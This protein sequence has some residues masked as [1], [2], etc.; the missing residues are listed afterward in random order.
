[1]IDCDD[2]FFVL[3]IRPIVRIV[4]SLYLSNCPV[5]IT[6]CHIT[7]GLCPNEQT[8]GGKKKKRRNNVRFCHKFLKDS[9][10]FL[11]VLLT[12]P[13]A[14]SLARIYILICPINVLIYVFLPG[15]TLRENLAFWDEVYWIQ[16]AQ[17]VQYIDILHHILYTYIYTRKLRHRQLFSDLW[18][19]ETHLYPW[20]LVSLKQQKN[21]RKIRLLDL[22]TTWSFKIHYINNRKRSHL[23]S[24]DAWQ[25]FSYYIN[26]Y[27]K[28][29]S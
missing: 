8:S 14:K 17:I 18:P 5:N 24:D 27:D 15:V 13:I 4:A 2:I 23:Q 11:C 21:W 1:M 10:N 12:T 22:Q 20:P 3:L 9:D 29:S 26:D 25:K 16:C 28:T 7:N 6:F 19:V